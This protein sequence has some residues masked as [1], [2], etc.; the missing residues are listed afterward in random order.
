MSAVS[1]AL[2]AP[3]WANPAWLLLIGVAAF[4]VIALRVRIDRVPSHDDWVAATTFVREQL[5][6]S[7]AIVVAPSWA[8]PLLRLHLGDRISAKV[9]G[10]EDLAAFERLWVLSLRGA[11]APEEPR[12]SPD[13]RAM[14]GRIAVSRYDFGPTPVVMD[15]VDALPSASVAI[16]RSGAEQ[17]CP[18]HERVPGVI[19]GGLGFG[20][21]APRQRFVCDDK[22]PWLWVGTTILEDLALAP[23]RCIFQHPQGREPI[24]VTFRNVHLGKKLVLYAGLD[25]HH[26]RDQVGAPVTMRVS[27]SGTELGRLIHRDGDGMKRV[28]MSTR[29]PGL[30]IRGDL[31]FEVSTDRPHLRSF[32]WAGSIQDTT[33]REAP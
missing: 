29:A 28:E 14:H 33:R 32:C 20:P 9:A 16:Q 23:R 15:F 13:F 26:E 7:D 2:H 19:R 5:D 17:E 8:D 31:R 12:R 30:G 22:R 6:T 11:R 10:R 25:Y 24:S 18:Y 27:S 21:A 4:E 1:G 3:R